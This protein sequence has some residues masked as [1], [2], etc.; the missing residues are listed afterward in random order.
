MPDKELKPIKNY[1]ISY[2]SQLK[3]YWCFNA[4]NRKLSSFS[5]KPKWRN[6]ASYIY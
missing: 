5:K 6:P 4:G 1:S 3:N 2:Y